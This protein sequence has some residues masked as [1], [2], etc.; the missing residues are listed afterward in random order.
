MKKPL[1]LK[2]LPAVLVSV[3]LLSLS[4][5]VAGGLFR[6]RAEDPLPDLGSLLDYP[7][8]IQIVDLVGEERDQIIDDLMERP[9]AQQLRWA[10][11]GKGFAI[12]LSEA[13][14]MSVTVGTRTIDVVVAPASVARWVF[15][16]LVMRGYGASDANLALSPPSVNPPAGEH[17]SPSSRASPGGSVA[18]LTAMVADDDTSFFQA[19]HTNLDPRLAA[20]PSHAIVVNQMPYFYITTLQVVDDQVVIWRYWW[21]DSHHHPDWYYA[22]YRHYWDYYHGAGYR[23]PGWYHWA[24]GWYYWRFWY[25]WSAWFPWLTTGE[26]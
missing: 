2:A 4:S 21:Y 23:W 9:E 14:A 26:P 3:V 22:F 11:L 12:T 16:P 1:I 7:G 6:F 5:A 8:Q 19:H 20:S 17:S 25:Y 15:L 10:L 24:Y 13:E 18:Y